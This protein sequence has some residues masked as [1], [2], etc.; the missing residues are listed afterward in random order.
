MALY[1]RD[2]RLRAALGVSMPKMVMPMRRLLA[3]R[4]TWNDALA[5]AAERAV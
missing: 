5:F 3:E 4:A 2:G 1:G